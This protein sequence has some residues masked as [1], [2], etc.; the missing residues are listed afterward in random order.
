MNTTMFKQLA[1]ME[2]VPARRLYCDPVILWK[3]ARMMFNCNE[4]PREVEHTEAFYRRFL[5]IP[6]EKS[7]EEKNQ[8]KELAKK[9]IDVELAGVFN[10]VLEG[11]HRLLDQKNFTVCETIDKQ[12][13]EYRHNSNSVACFIE[14]GYYVKSVETSMLL[15]EV[16]SEYRT[17]CHSSG[18]I[19]C[20]AINFGNRLRRLGF[21]V[22]RKNHGN[23]VYIKTDF[24]KGP[25]GV[26]DFILM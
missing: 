23:V 12:V 8:D 6:F 11:L 17:Y 4:L 2:P 21:I 5:I 24:P 22:E 18:L 14:E 10:W 1:S 20:S 7:I 19:A 25:G 26:I 9:I 3:Y 15:K 13:E 16:Y